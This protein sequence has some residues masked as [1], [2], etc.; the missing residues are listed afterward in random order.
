MNKLSPEAAE[1]L[2]AA[3]DRQVESARKGIGLSQ[4]A[5]LWDT[6][7]SLVDGGSSKPRSPYKQVELV[8]ACINK[9]IS[10]IGGLPPVISN[11]KEEII[12]SGPAYDLLF[13]SPSLGW[14]RFVT[15]T[16]GHYALS[17]DVFWVFTDMAGR[18]PKEITVVSGT[19][20]HA[21]THDRTASGVLLGWEFRGAGGRRAT[22]TLDEVWQWK[23]FNPYDPYHGIGPAVAAELSINYSYAASLFNT[24][25][26]NNGA[27][28]GIILTMPG[29]LDEDQIRMHRSQFD[30]RHAGAGKAKRTVLLAGGMDVKTVAQT[31]VDMDVA[32]LTD[33]SDNKI[34][35]CFEVPPAVV[36]LVTEAQYSHGPAQ[37]DLIFNTIIPLAALFAGNITSGIL[38]LFYTDSARGVAL[39]DAKLYHGQKHLSL[40]RR[41]FFRDAF[42]KAVSQNRSV[43]LWFDADQHPTVQEAKREVAK[44]VLDSTNSGVTLNNLIEAHDLPYELNE[45]GEHWW[46][47][48]GQIPADYAL[49]AGLEGLTGPSLPEGTPSGEEEGRSQIANRVSSIEN[50]VS[51]IENRASKIEH[52]ESS[53]EK[54]SQLQRLRIWRSWVISWAGIEREYTE[55]MRKYFL[56]QQRIL[57]SKLKA[58]MNP[59]SRTL[60]PEPRTDEIIAR[61]VFD[62]KLDN[63]KIKVINHTFFDKAAE[64]GIRQ[65]LSE[66]AGLTGAALDEAAASVRLSLK[67][68]GKMRLSSSKI[69]GINATTQR[70]VAEQLKAGL[71]SGEGLSELSGR[72]K[73]V[74]GS[75]RARAISIARTQTAGAVGTGR[76]EGMKSAGIKLKGWLT[77]GDKDVRPAH[78]AAGGRYAAGIAVDVPFEVGGE[79]LMY[80]GDPAGSAGN[81]INCRCCEIAIASAGKSYGIAHYS[82]INFYSYSDMQ[83][84]L[85]TTN[86]EPRTTNKV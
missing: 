62:L 77:S 17:R 2:K 20:M 38:S 21:V 41:S 86:H 74:L 54:D 30:S 15:E 18:R 32:A 3:V 39:K 51:S 85:R 73:K 34:C 12:E 75:N 55:A 44:S 22:F 63:N 67:I 16:I 14:E 8:F 49:E 59:E 68:T 53:I 78:I 5:R 80:P 13:K 79:F 72:I 82:N 57:L 83:K 9:L 33:K 69:T 19:Q 24:S 64:L 7:Q 27:E 28:P 23:N 40:S 31:M 71:E 1:M 52:R 47:T 42:H 10:G 48:M 84:E 43:F 45:W 60:N 25:A 61:I 58:A 81:I 50:Q 70:M 6:G 66:I 4:L 76:H 65:S 26:L 36:G 35:A 29:S 11:I 56:R 37:K 46:I